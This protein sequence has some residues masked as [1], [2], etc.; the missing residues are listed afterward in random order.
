[1]TLRPTLRRVVTIA[2]LAFAWCALWGEVTPANLVSGLVVASI[3]VGIGV[4]TPGRGGIRLRPLLRFS[5]HVVADMVTSTLSVAREIL[6][7][8]DRTDEAIVAVP[9]PTEARSHLLLLIVAVTVTPGTAVVDADPDTGTL[10]LHLLHAERRDATTA[11][12]QMLADLASRALPTGN[13]PDF[14]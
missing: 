6:T 2:G 14:A 8:E 13:R 9:V 3:V 5:A 12:V 10:F 11:H 1:M 4:G 7:P